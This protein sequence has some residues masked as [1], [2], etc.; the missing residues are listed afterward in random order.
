MSAALLKDADDSVMS[1][2]IILVLVLV[3]IVI[4][5]GT[6]SGLSMNLLIID[7]SLL[8]PDPHNLPRV[9]NLGEGLRWQ[10]SKKDLISKVDLD[11]VL[12]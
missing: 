9:V 4:F 8:W 1:E 2:N 7:L 12:N 5:P 3:I 11:L 10:N 6:W